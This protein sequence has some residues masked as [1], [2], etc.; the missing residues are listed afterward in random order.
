LETI[1]VK[2][3]RT[4]QIA[5]LKKRIDGIETAINAKI[6]TLKTVDAKNEFAEMLPE[7]AVKV[8]Y[9]E[10]SMSKLNIDGLKSR[11][12][13]LEENTKKNVGEFRTRLDDFSETFNKF[14]KVW[15][16]NEEGLTINDHFQGQN[17]EKP[18]LVGE[19]LVD[20]QGNEIKD[21]PKSKLL[22]MVLGDEKVLQVP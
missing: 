8:E 10:T 6:D 7:L 12:F 1:N 17:V 5:E 2:P 4:S 16:H 13:D 21:K 22:S 11:L 20:E 15:G 19:K 3:K 18:F 14:K 9:L